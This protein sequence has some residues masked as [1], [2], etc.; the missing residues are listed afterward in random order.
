MSAQAGPPNA[1]SAPPPPAVHPAVRAAVAG[2]PA[3][4]LLE[5]RGP[6]PAE[7]AGMSA[8]E[9]REAA[10]AAQDRLLD[11]PAGRRT[12]V[13]RRYRAV[14]AL[15][16]RADAVALDALER[17]PDVVSITPDARGSA[18]LGQ[19]LPIVH[20][21]EVHASGLTG[22]GVTVAVLDSGIDTDHPDLQDGIAYERC[23]LL[24]GCPPEPHPAEDDHGH[25]TNVSGIVT[26]N[27]LVAPLGVAPD[28]QIAAYKVLDSD[29]SGFFSDW[30]AALDDII[31]AH[32]E[33]N[34]VNMSLQST[35]LCP[36][37]ALGGAIATLRERDVPVFIATGN[38]GIKHTFYVPA[39][40][41]TSITVGAA[42]DAVLAKVNGWKTTCSDSPTA[43]DMVAC[44]SDSAPALDLLA[45]GAPISAPGVGG[46]ISTFFGTSQASPHA[47]GIAALLLQ[48]R[49]GLSVDEIEHRLE[50]TGPI[51]SDDLN[52][53]D[54]ATNRATPRVDARVALLTDDGD[55]DGDGCSDIEELGPELRLGGM[56]NPLNPYDFYDVNG[57]R[58]VNMLDDV[59]AVASAFG[60]AKDPNYDAALDRSPPP[61]GAQPWQLGPPDGA[62]GITT[63]VMAAVA[64]FGHNCQGP[65]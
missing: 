6:S 49:P 24:S 19:S 21:P 12:E 25:G 38:H 60:L 33:V 27:G 9:L 20:A 22:A 65:P 13:L 8:P 3:R 11:S 57:D 15:A 47:A 39:C 29:G 55:F 50:A 59:L 14:P 35:A 4:V 40:V 51:L 17:R 23:F 58:A 52:D 18:A 28:A 53:A 42:Y 26:S 16:L 10:A 2:G 32:P 46:G 64:Q 34:I 48:A 7:A 62:I 63:D 36:G 41:D 56:R 43:V 1:E 30:L 5:L 45:P 44:W 31:A 61:P 54:P 37:G